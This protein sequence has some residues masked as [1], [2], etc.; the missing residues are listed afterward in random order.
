MGER[1]KE[2]DRVN[3][4]W[5][6]PFN[7]KSAIGNYSKHATEALSKFDNVDIYVYEDACIEEESLFETNL[8]VK[9]YSSPDIADDL[10][11]YD[12]CVY[13]MGNY[14][15]YHSVI[16][17]VMQ[18]HAGIVIAHDI[19]MQDFAIE[20]Y[21]GKKG[22]IQLYRDSLVKEYGEPVADQ[23]MRAL[24]S[25]EEWKKLD[26][27]KY[28]MLGMI[29]GEALGVIVHSHYHKN[30]IE[31]H[32]KGPV[33]VT[34]LLSMN[35]WH[36]SE[37]E[38]V[39]E[40]KDNKLNILTVGMV[41]PNKHIDLVIGAIAESEELKKR[42]KYVVIGSLA[43][44]EYVEKLKKMIEENHLEDV[45]VLKGYMDDDEM[46]KYYHNA[47]LVINLRYP[48]FEGGSA[49]LVEQMT[50][51]KCVIATD[52]GVYAEMPDEC[53][54][55]ISPAKMRE[56]LKEKLLEL[57]ENEEKVNQYEEN[58]KKY[59]ESNFSRTVYGKR[60]HDFVEEVV[61]SL[62][63]YEIIRDTGESLQCL[64]GTYMDEKISNEIDALFG[65]QRG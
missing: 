11:Q 15:A 27:V 61:F 50:D 1:Y 57:C 4:A 65:I 21:C 23:V 44:K 25:P 12:V 46:G 20:H 54:C 42:I 41:N 6:T 62:P 29:V 60:V 48:A 43:A 59:A 56:E 34:P 35:Q 3:I 45:V 2:V 39:S 63:I 51:G 31:E 24:A 7:K 36:D 14:A 26:V 49:S 55:K 5:F 38:M 16:Y 9:K 28:N 37:R 64:K 19:C 40:N 22:S 32:Y 53:I 30:Y 8:C 18:R 33:L 47:D 58:A 10:G 52:T 17:E 13:N